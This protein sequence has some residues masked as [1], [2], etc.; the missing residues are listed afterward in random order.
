MLWRLWPFLLLLFSSACILSSESPVE[1]SSDDVN[2][3]QRGD[4][5]ISNINTDS[6]VLLDE[7]GVYKATLV[8]SQIDATLIYNGLHF[9]EVNN[10]LLFIYDSTTAVL[11]AVKKIDLYDGTV[12]TV[13]SNS[14]LTGTMNALA[15]L[16]G[17]DLLV[18]ETTTTAEKFNSS[19]VRQGA[20]FI[21]TLTATIADINPTITGGFI[22]CSSGT[23]NTVR[24]YTSAGVV[25]ATA[26]SAAPVPSLGA[27]A[28]TS[29]VQAADGTI[30]VAYSGATDAVRAYNS[31]MTTTLWTFTDT[32]IF[33]TPGKMALR[34]NGNI[35]VT[36]TGFHHI[37][38]IDTNGALVQVIGG[39]VL[40]NPA[41]IA[42]VK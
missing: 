6:I 20:P 24:T 9:D 4:I 37:V 5:V 12:T 30:Y 19:G 17:G 23:A 13:L 22:A 28:A 27:L 10:E 1:T 11:D 32:N 40:N 3:I 34:E 26:T 35:L 39:T 33:T 29:C 18:T 36:D 41:H 31:T 25:Q 38:E 15:R 16:T 7:N 42:V 21:S 8:D 14:N 2:L